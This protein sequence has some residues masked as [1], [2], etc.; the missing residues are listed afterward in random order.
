MI[1]LNLFFYRFFIQMFDSHFLK[2]C[3]NKILCVIY[4]WKFY[5]WQKNISRFER[6]KE[7]QKILQKNYVHKCWK[8]FIQFLI[9]FQFLIFVNGEKNSFSIPANSNTKFLFYNLK[10]ESSLYRCVQFCFSRVCRTHKN[11]QLFIKL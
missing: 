10:A 3:I 8:H 7:N 11:F 6:T 2:K 5:R 4:E 9:F 1:F